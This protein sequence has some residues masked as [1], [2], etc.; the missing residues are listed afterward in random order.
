MALV[1]VS[2]SGKITA[3]KRR[4][5]EAKFREKNKNCISSRNFAPSLLRGKRFFEGS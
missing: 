3:K 2:F 5:E 1:L 4:S